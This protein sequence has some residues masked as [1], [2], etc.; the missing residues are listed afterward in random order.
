[1]GY[2]KEEMKVLEKLAQEIFGMSFD[3]L[4]DDDQDYVYC[5]SQEM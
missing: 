5:M 1:M 2:S 3:E 4:D